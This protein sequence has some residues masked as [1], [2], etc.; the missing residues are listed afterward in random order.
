VEIGRLWPREAV[1]KN[2]DKIRGGSKV[3]GGGRIDW[4]LRKGAMGAPESHRFWRP[5][6][7]GKF[8]A[9]VA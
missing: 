3:E 9:S 5:Q 2:L 8:G 6:R 4:R 1:M 7:G